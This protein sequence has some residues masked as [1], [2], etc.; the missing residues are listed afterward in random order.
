[1]GLTGNANRKAAWR[2]LRRRMPLVVGPGLGQS[3]VAQKRLLALAALD[4]PMVVLDADGLNL[5]SAMKKWPAANSKP[6][7]C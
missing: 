1:M 6:G 2:R 7:R 5:M 3:P 4:R